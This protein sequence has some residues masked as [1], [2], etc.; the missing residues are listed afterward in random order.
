MKFSKALDA[1]VAQ[2]DSL[3]DARRSGASSV[4]KE[5]RRGETASLAVRANVDVLV[6]G[7]ADAGTQQLSFMRN[8]LASYATVSEASNGHVLIGD[9]ARNPQSDILLR[10]LAVR[11]DVESLRREYRQAVENRRAVENARMKMAA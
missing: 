3:V 2:V 5:R 8:G 10:G 7:C 4:V 9:L 6:S 1:G 11:P